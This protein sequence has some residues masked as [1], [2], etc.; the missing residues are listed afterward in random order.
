M[1]NKN[2]GDE[3]KIT[4]W[5]FT[6]TID[7]IEKDGGNKIQRLYRCRS[8]YALSKLIMDDRLEDLWRKENPY[9]SNFTRY[10][11]YFG[12]RSKIYRVYPD[13]KIANNTKI[14]Y[15]M[16]SFTDHYNAISIDRLP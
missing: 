4:H 16:I 10:D 9:S 11:R 2:E 8:D 15:I 1:D 5:D 6:C 12:R 3:N 13:V 14:I 7:K